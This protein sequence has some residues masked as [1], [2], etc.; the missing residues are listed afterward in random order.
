MYVHT[1]SYQMVQHHTDQRRRAQSEII[2]SNS[3]P[4]KKSQS[5]NTS[6]LLTKTSSSFA[7]IT[8]HY[9][10][11]TTLYTA[12]YR[13]CE[14]KHYRTALAVGIQ[15]C[16]VALFDIPLHSYYNSPKYKDLKIES[17]N[18]AIQVSDLLPT[19]VA[20][21]ASEAR[22]DGV[23]FD[24]KEKRE[25]VLTL[26]DIARDHYHQLLYPSQYFDEKH[27]ENNDE[28]LS[29]SIEKRDSHSDEGKRW[30]WDCG[31]SNLSLDLCT[32]HSKGLP[33]VKEDEKFDEFLENGERPPQSLNPSQIKH[34]EECKTEYNDTES[35]YSYQVGY[36]VRTNEE[37]KGYSLKSRESLQFDADLKRA[38]S[39][40]GLD[41]QQTHE[42][43]TYDE[44]Y[45][46]LKP[47]GSDMIDFNTLA[48]L[49]KDDFFELQKNANIQITFVDTYQGRVRGSLNG[50]TVIAPLLAIHHM[51][52]DS[53]SEVL[54]SRNAI[55]TEGFSEAKRLVCESID[56][57]SSMAPVLSVDGSLHDDLVRVVIDV[58]APKV[59]TL[60]RES[61][62]LHQ[63]AL[64]I[65]SDVHDFLIEHNMLQQKQFID[66]VGG[67]ILDDEHVSTFISKFNNACET[68][69]GKK[70][71]ATFFFHEHVVSLHRVTKKIYTS[72]RSS[73]GDSTKKSRKKIFRKLRK[74]KNKLAKNDDFDT[75]IEEEEVWF[76]LI[77]S[78]PGAKMLNIQEGIKDF[79]DI[80]ITSTAR[81]RCKNIK[82]LQACIRW[83]AC[84]K[85]SNKDE[86]FIDTYQFD[87]CNMEFDPRVFQAFLFMECRC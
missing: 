11:N 64:I 5:A 74:T 21:A 66:V 48:E 29:N 4:L 42:D 10:L 53:S 34:D 27:Y 47:V 58:Q 80:E 39:I 8:A 62:N 32:F 84:S 49:Y 81:I 76:E 14:K 15:F 59:L 78:L 31:T 69:S 9:S 68:D 25:E 72:I 61:L 45:C 57:T 82:S 63:D 18:F 67:N 35:H 60:V 12:F 7:P 85:L 87:A 75:V 36:S 2:Q 20:M 37:P 40:S 6:S 13:L 19:I 73:D 38:L 83:Y 79:D 23:P 41:I 70:V 33:I 28:L 50:C 30:N 52:S 26:R 56:E 1:H 77:D 46:N 22:N 3:I 51:S 44:R 86:K 24:M 43:N 71:A 16:R 54:S 65:P 17:A 55:L